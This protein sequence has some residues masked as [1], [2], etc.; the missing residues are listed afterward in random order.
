MVQNCMKCGKP[1]R[2]IGNQRKNGKSFLNHSN[3]SNDWK[4]RQFHKKCY[5]E[6]QED[7]WY[8]YLESERELAKAKLENEIIRQNLTNSVTDLSTT[9]DENNNTETINTDKFIVSFN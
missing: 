9:T 6:H 2:K 8:K 3:F 4:E 5:K 1:L 7:I